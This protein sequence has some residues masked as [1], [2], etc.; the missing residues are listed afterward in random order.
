MPYCERVL[1]PFSPSRRLIWGSIKD[2]VSCWTHVDR[3]ERNG[4][5]E[6]IIPNLDVLVG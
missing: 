2:T 6:Y 4:V 5:A 1:A 3:L